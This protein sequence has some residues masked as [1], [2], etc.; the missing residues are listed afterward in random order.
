MQDPAGLLGLQAAFEERIGSLS[1][2]RHVVTKG[3]DL[4]SFTWDPTLNSLIK[5]H[6]K[7]SFIPVTH[8]ALLKRRSCATEHGRERR[9]L[10]SWEVKK[11][12][13]GLVWKNC[14]VIPLS[15]TPEHTYT[16]RC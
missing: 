13:A 7:V 16:E 9:G 15:L 10:H 12:F 1:L 14:T 4:W 8:G 11:D 2:L 3:Q 5:S 6:L